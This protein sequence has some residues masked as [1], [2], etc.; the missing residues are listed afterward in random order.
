[1][2]MGFAERFII[3]FFNLIRYPIYIFYEKIENVINIK[4][5]DFLKIEFDGS[6]FFSI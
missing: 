6:K 3:I 4:I 5:I 1:M 2:V